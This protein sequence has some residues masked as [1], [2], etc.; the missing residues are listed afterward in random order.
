MSATIVA[1][2]LEPGQDSSVQ[3]RINLTAYQSLPPGEASQTINYL[4]ECRASAA[5]AG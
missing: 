2:G 5:T 1:P 3:F 4:V